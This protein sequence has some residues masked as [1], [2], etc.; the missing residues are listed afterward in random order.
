MVDKDLINLAIRVQN[1]V[2][3]ILI[4]ISTLILILSISG[5]LFY[6]YESY[7]NQIYIFLSSTGNLNLSL[8]FMFFSFLELILLLV[9]FLFNPNRA[10]KFY[11]RQLFVLGTL[12]IVYLVSLFLFNLVGYSKDNFTYIILI[13]SILISI[14]I[15]SAFVDFGKVFK[16]YPE[17]VYI[18]FSL[19]LVLV[20]ALLL[21]LPISSSK[22]PIPFIDALFVATSAV[23]V[24]GLTTIDV[25]R[26]LSFWGQLFLMFFIQLGGITIIVVSVLGIFYGIISGDV[27]TKIK[28]G[29]ILNVK[30]ADEAWNLIRRFLILVFASQFVVSIVIFPTIYSLEK[31][32]WKSVFF[33]VFHAVSAFNNAGFSPYSDSLA[34]FR[35]NT[36]FLL[37]I[38]YLI[39]LG[40]TGVVVL[41]DIY[42]WVKYKFSRVFY[43]KR[44]EDYKGFSLNSKIFI[45]AHT[46]VII[47]GIIWFLMFE[48][49][50]L[51]VDTQ[52]PLLNALFSSISFRTAGFQLF[53]FSEAKSSTYIFFSIIMFIGGGSISTA[54]G[55]KVGTIA[56]M[57]LAIKAILR[58]ESFITAF[59]R[60]VSNMVVIRSI[61][62]VTA[63]FV[64]VLIVI[65]IL[66]EIIPK[67]FDRIIFESL[68]AFAT[69]GTTSGITSKYMSPL[70]K[71]V[72]I[73]T[74]FVGKIGMISFLIIISRKGYR[75]V[76][77][78]PE[79]KVLVG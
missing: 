19:L 1:I 24:T 75:S 13:P 27:V 3:T 47:L 36:L 72:L 54:G 58:S 5:L 29:G 21:I 78:Y 17:L 62:I 53:D 79:D 40:N 38:I 51:L 61:A 56:V 8:I 69:V 2:K 25:G 7:L 41:D 60:T 31:D 18:I 67:D 64:F 32:F 77:K 44:V 43:K 28:M 20:C 52:K 65:S 23:S 48:Y 59:G 73:I 45:T 14:G 10:D 9:I 66:Y 26:E 63:S 4:I 34:K 35:E 39:V 55:V 33:S 30:S 49:D 71:I 46:I 74:M 68:S 57:F 42:R 16:L 15:W 37:A 11:H 6:N 50:N 12:I 76:S 22:D 70:G